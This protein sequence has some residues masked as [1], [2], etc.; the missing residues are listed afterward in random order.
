MAGQI[1]RMLDEIIR[2]RAK[3]DHT[4]TQTTKTKLILKGFNPDKYTALS[5]DSPEVIKKIRAVAAEMGIRI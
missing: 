3:G 4:L 5:E 1:K 2:Q